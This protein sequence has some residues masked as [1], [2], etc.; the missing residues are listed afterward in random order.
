[1]DCWVAILTLTF[2]TTRKVE[3]SAVSAGRLHSQETPW[4]SFLLQAEWT[5]Q[6]YSM[7]TEGLRHLKISKNPTGN[8]NRDLPFCG[9]MSRQTAPP[10]A[11]FDEQHKPQSYSVRSFLQAAFAFFRSSPSKFPNTLL[12]ARFQT[13]AEVSFR[14]SLF[15]DVTQRILAYGR[16]GTAYRF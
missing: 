7:R 15:W 1:M 14:F 2:G 16:F 6:C 10:L 8:R 4:Y 12:H 5:A 11:P 13:S 9:T 3:L